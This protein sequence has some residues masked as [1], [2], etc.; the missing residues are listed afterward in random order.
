MDRNILDQLDPR[1]LG[2]RLQDARRAR[3]LTQQ[4]VADLLGIARTTLVAIEKGERRVLPGELIRLA[5]IYSRPVSEFVS[6]PVLVEGFVPQFRA[7]WKDV[8]EEDPELEKSAGELQRLAED[9]L[10]LERLC[11][12][13]L[14]RAYPPQYE[15]S[16][17]SAEQ[18]AEEIAAAERNRLGIGDGPVSNLRDR[19]E[20]DIGLRIFYFPMASKIAGLFAYN[21]V[22][23]G[24]IGINS[25]HPRDR[26]HW[27]LAHECGHFL[28][29]RYQ[30]E[31]TFLSEK[32]RASLRERIADSFAKYFL[33][34]ASG[35]NRR[36]TETHRTSERGITLAHVCTLAD[37]YQVSVQAMVLRLEE[38]RRLPSGTWE[39]LEAGGFK[40]RSAQQL[41][42]IDANTPIQHL[43]PQ[44]YVNLAILAY[45]QDKLS[46]GQLARFLRMD[47]IA[48]REQLD[49]ATRR[50]NEEGDENFTSI[51]LD[52]AAQLD[53]R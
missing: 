11:D 43:L 37:L 14:V 44:R 7:S 45:R 13:P 46:E 15:V 22:L 40:V 8:F 12:M 47:R 18:V 25:A 39:R 33:M 10:E 9:Y 4:A 3:G 23:G 26:R 30:S 28:T 1:L 5:E 52:L 16:G 17:A 50:F 32:K 34:P 31:I 49:N 42:G 6:R 38:L 36:F 21:E 2:A 35:L 24:C 41:L 29:G 19:L 48:A 53:G 51:D 20:N 27:S